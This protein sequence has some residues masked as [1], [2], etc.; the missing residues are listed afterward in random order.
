MSMWPSLRDGHCQMTAGS[1]F[2]A[3]VMTLPEFRAMLTAR[4]GKAML[5]NVASTMITRPLLA[6]STRCNDRYGAPLESPFAALS[7]RPIS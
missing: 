4:S 6:V 2:Y 7:G 1:A 3:T 5:A